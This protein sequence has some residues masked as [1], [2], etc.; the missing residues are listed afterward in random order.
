MSKA[1]R[2]ASK[3]MTVGDLISELCRWPDHAL[4]KF[5]YPFQHQELRFD[6]IE[7]GTKGI[8]EIELAAA[9]KST[10]VVAA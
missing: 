8:V 1:T 2:K 6:H 10:P 3:P 4:V 7:G 9:S 5:R